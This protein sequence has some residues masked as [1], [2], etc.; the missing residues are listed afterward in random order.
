MSE[1][2]L[3]YN[4]NKPKWSLIPQ[5]ALIPMVR[6]AE[7]GATKYA[8]HNWKKG[9]KISEICESLKRHLDD[10]MEGKDIDPES[11]LPHTC[12]I[13]WNSMALQWMLDNRPD[14]D[15]RWKETK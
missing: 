4:T 9:L 12:G 15:D 11:D 8:P 5:S 14:M 10:F 6:A 2:G 1:T 3:R 13:Q 7:Y